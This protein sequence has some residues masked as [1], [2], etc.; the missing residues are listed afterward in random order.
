MFHKINTETRH[1]FKKASHLQAYKMHTYV[2]KNNSCTTR[3]KNAH[4]SKNTRDII[5]G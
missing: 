1:F 2:Y 4:R 3:I 5:H